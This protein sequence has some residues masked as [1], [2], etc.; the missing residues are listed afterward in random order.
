MVMDWI[1]ERISSLAWA[2]LIF[3]PY[4]AASVALYFILLPK[5]HRESDVVHAVIPALGRQ[6]Q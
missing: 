3:N 4:Q 1:Q 2:T 5:L 6:R